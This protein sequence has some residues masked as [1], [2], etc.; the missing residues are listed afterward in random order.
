[1]SKQRTTSRLGWLGIAETILEDSPEP[2][3][4]NEIVRR[5]V[6]RKLVETDTE[7]PD[8]TVQAAIWRNIRTLGE[9][10]PFVMVGEGRS[11]RKYWLR[12]KLKRGKQ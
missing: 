8:H 11:H 7:T 12:S 3:H 6:Q 5:A 1:M 9:C 2:L 10:S 4:S